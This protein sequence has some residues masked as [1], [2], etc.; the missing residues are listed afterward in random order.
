MGIKIKH[1]DPKTTDFSKQDIVINIKDGSLFYKS[2]I[3]VHKV[4]ATQVLHHVTTVTTNNIGNSQDTQILYNNNGTIDGDSGIYY[5]NISEFLYSNKKVSINN[6]LNLTSL[7]TTPLGN[8]VN[9][10]VSGGSYRSTFKEGNLMAKN[11]AGY[12]IIGPQNSKAADPHYR[13]CH[14][15]TDKTDYFFDKPIIV[16]NGVVSSFNEDLVLTTSEGSILTG[17]G[18]IR[19]QNSVAGVEIKGDVS[20][21]AN[22]GTSVGQITANGALFTG[23]NAFLNI[24]RSGPGYSIDNTAGNGN[25]LLGDVYA[26]SYSPSSDKKLKKNIKPLENSLSKILKLDGVTFE[27]KKTPEKGTQYG[28]IAQEVQKIIPE[29]VVMSPKDSK[30]ESSLHLNYN[31]IIPVLVEALKDQQK[32][33]DELKSKIK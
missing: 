16:D 33:I 27:W 1:R 5:N 11:T 20:I 4:T 32:Q 10:G 7:P 21:T 18:I 26:L 22:G 15:E 30:G 14:F 19:I 23:T 6:D 3:G 12:I 13:Y 25:T 28:F 24:N 31:G 29:L 8:Q 2:E 17:H 9:L